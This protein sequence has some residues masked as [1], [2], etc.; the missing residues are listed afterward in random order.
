MCGA[1]D[2]TLS[3][4]ALPW[5]SATGDDTLDYHLTGG[6]AE[7]LV[8]ALNIPYE[9]SSDYDGDARPDGALRDAGADE[10]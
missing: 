3:G 7:D 4:G 9:L 10:R 1:T 5:T 6:V 2:T 8:P